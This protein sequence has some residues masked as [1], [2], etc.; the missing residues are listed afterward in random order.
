MRWLKRWIHSAVHEYYTSVEGGDLPKKSPRTGVM[1]VLG[2][3]AS[4]M[5]QIYRIDNGFIVTINL[6]SDANFNTRGACVYAK[7]ASEVAEKI[8]A[9]ETAFKLGVH[10]RSRGITGAA[11]APATAYLKPG[12]I[13]HYKLLAEIK[14]LKGSWN[15]V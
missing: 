7:D 6:S 3:M 5:A 10:E 11:Q 13:E 15:N 14:K 1:D 2:H 8:I 12:D 9:H 4:S